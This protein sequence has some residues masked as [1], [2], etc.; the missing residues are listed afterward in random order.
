MNARTFGETL[1]HYLKQSGMTQEALAEQ[2]GVTQ[3]AISN[4]KADRKRPSSEMVKALA[5]ALGAPFEELLQAAGRGGAEPK[6]VQASGKAAL[7]DFKSQIREARLKRL[8]FLGGLPCGNLG[9]IPDEPEEYQ[10]WPESLI[11]GADY[12]FEVQGDSM[13][14][15]GYLDGN[16]VFVRHYRPGEVPRSGDHVLATLVD[17]EMRHQTLK[18]F[19]LVQGKP[20][21]CPDSTNGE[22]ESIPVDG[23]VY[24]TGKVVWTC[25][26]PRRFR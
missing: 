25:A 19:A 9:V 23:N 18:K 7:Q 2:I 21:L 15:L 12:V 22:H 14:R 26:N 11:N 10:D 24:V 16:L 1:G 13:D 5:K 6:P 20:M 17:G 8:P 4:L 3:G